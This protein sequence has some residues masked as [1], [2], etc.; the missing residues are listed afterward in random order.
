MSRAFRL[1]FIELGTQRL[2]PELKYYT[3]VIGAKVTECGA[4][5]S[6]YLSLGL[7][8]HKVALKTSEEAGLQGFGLQETSDRPLEDWAVHL[9]D[10]GLT[11]SLKTDA[12]PGVPKLLE[13]SEPGGQVL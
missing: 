12:R 9:K 6:V 13:V 10:R 11:A 1:G 4:D 2:E 7:D 8:H 3:E 5:G